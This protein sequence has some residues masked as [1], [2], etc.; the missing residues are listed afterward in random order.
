MYPWK[1]TLQRDALV[2]S[3]ITDITPIPRP[4]CLWTLCTATCRAGL[5]PAP[6]MAPDRM[7]A[8]QS[9]ICSP[10]LQ[11]VFMVYVLLCWGVFF[12]FSHCTPQWSIVWGLIFFSSSLSSCKCCTFLP[13]PV[14]LFCLPRCHMYVVYVW[15]GWWLISLVLVTSDNKGLLL[16][17][18]IKTKKK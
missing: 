18:Q 3:P 5:W 11:V 4:N 6:Q 7:A 10:L 8:C 16:L 9:W 12:L 15:T 1:G 17:L 14:F 2:P 13:F